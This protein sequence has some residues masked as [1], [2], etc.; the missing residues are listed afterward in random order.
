[1]TW[2]GTTDCILVSLLVIRFYYPLNS[3][4]VDNAIGESDEN[5]NLTS[6]KFV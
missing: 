4:A 3:E 1:M 6:D 2:Y 5:E